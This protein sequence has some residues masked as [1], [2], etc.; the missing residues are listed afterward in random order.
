MGDNLGKT[1]AQLTKDNS[2]GD[3]FMR[4]FLGAN[5]GAE[6]LATWQRAEALVKNDKIGTSPYTYKRGAPGQPGQLTGDVT[7]ADHLSPTVNALSTAQGK[8]KMTGIKNS[9]LLDRTAVLATGAIG[10]QNSVTAPLADTVM[11]GYGLMADSEAEIKQWTWDKKAGV[12]L[13][14]MDNQ[15]LEL[16]ASIILNKTINAKFDPIKPTLAQEYIVRIVK[17]AHAAGQLNLVIGACDAFSILRMLDK[18]NRGEI[19]TILAEGY[20][21]KI[22]LPNAINQCR[23]WVDFNGSQS[24]EALAIYLS[25]KRNYPEKANLL[26]KKLLENKVKIVWD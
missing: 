5:M 14:L 7:A 1:F 11:G 15:S 24:A 2:V 19:T 4:D 17:A 26:K 22:D 12:L 23:K 18:A 6:R 25:I 20:Y 13:A 10:A 16:V 21:P 8:P 3:D 9:A